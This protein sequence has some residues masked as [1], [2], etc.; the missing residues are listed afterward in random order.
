MKYH[1]FVNPIDSFAF[2]FGPVNHLKHTFSIERLPFTATYFG[3]LIATLYVSVELEYISL[4]ILFA[5]IQ[6]VSLVWY[7]VS[8][9][10]QGHATMKFL[11]GMAT[12]S[13]SSKLPV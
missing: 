6:I 4:T 1:Q 11:A 8:Y 5:I 13:V 12:R 3:S 7:F 10:P 2:L 9:L